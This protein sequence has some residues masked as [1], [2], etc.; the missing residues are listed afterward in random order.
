MGV[1]VV[2]KLTGAPRKLTDIFTD[3]NKAFTKLTPNQ[4]LGVMFEGFG[5]RGIVGAADLSRQLGDY[6]KVRSSLEDITGRSKELADV[7]N[8]DLLMRLKRLTNKALEKGF[9]ILD[10]YGDR[11]STML[12]KVMK[13]VDKFDIGPI[14][15][16]LSSAGDIIGFC[17]EVLKPFI[18]ALPWIAAGWGL[19]NLQ[20]KV[21][22]GLK[23][24]Y[25][26]WQIGAA[27]VAGL[28]PVR[29]MTTAM[30][31]LG[32]SLLTVA[33]PLLAIAAIGSLGAAAYSLVTGKDN[34]ISQIAQNLGLVPEL[35][36]DSEGHV[37]GYAQAP[38]A[39]TAGLGQGSYDLRIH[40][41]PAGSTFS[42]SSQ[43]APSIQGH[44][45]GQN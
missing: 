4:R 25:V 45:L 30:A 44:L 16:G 31:A 32:A 22:T 19:W 28:G 42:G 13:S 17:Y 2:D 36:H 18:P 9:E 43:G 38:N 5:L 34:F 6:E 14:A 12:D 24:A 29:A 35:G 21:F 7:I 26:W 20:L 10:K 23:V 33:T 27:M 11:F 8:D 15:S 41:A 1:N 40:N 39:K 3:M 37:N